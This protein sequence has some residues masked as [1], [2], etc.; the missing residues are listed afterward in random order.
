[1]LRSV[2]DTCAGPGDDGD[3]L[4]QLA[5]VAATRAASTWRPDGG[6]S[7]STWATN[8]AHAALA[9]DKRRARRLDKG[10]VHLVAID[11]VEPLPTDLSEATLGATWVIDHVRTAC[12]SLPPALAQR[13][14]GATTEV[15][16]GRNNSLG[17]RASRSVDIR[18]VLAHP[19]LGLRPL[20]SG[21]PGWSD[22]AACHNQPVG[23]FFPPR[24]ER[25]DAATVAICDSCAVR[26]ACLTEALEH[27]LRVGYR[28]G[29]SAASRR[30]L[31][32]HAPT[33]PPTTTPRGGSTTHG[34]NHAPAPPLSASH[35]T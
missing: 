16:A 30:Q 32:A 14:V 9:P 21:D 4:L 2:V 12:S 25:V 19:A 27:G 23:A 35:R 29:S 1:M 7:P 28:G 22:E 15:V 13:V 20:L 34:G 8:H 5:R 6:A 33:P 10:R 26:T 24:G 17:G 18:S 3:E 11:G 31:A